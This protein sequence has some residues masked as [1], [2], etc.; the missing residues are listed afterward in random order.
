[1]QGSAMHV[2]IKPSLGSHL[3]NSSKNS[4]RDFCNIT[5]NSFHFFSLLDDW[6]II[7]NQKHEGIGMQ[8]LTTKEA[9][10]KDS[11]PCEDAVEYED[12]YTKMELS[13]KRHHFR[14]WFGLLVIDIGFLF[15]CLIASTAAL[16]DWLDISDGSFPVLECAPNQMFFI[17]V[18]IFMIF[19]TVTIL[20][21]LLGVAVKKG[22]ENKTGMR[23]KN[24][25]TEELICSTCGCGHSEHEKFCPT[26]GA[27]TI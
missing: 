9:I 14:L 19:I 22:G 5:R 15:F 3:R 24:A 20:L 6:E 13:E 4:T 10:Q 1:M 7:I 17:W 26:C 12:E 16:A 23:M 21:I 11:A 2:P 25:K 27:S 18:Y 8:T